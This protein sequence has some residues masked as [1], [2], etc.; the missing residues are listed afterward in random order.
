M[1]KNETTA[2]KTNGNDLT[3][4]VFILD[5][6]GSMFSLAEDTVGGF[7]AML[8]KQKGEDG[9]CLVTTVFF[10]SEDRRVHDRI[11]LAEVPL[12]TGEDYRPGGCTALYDAMGHTVEHIRSIHRYARPEDVPARTLVIVTTDG[13][14]NA[15]RSY[16]SRKVR[17][18]VR[19]MQEEWGWEFL[20]LGANM[21]AIAAAENVGIRRE[22]ATTYAC[23]K[24]GTRLNFKA[25]AKVIGDVRAA[26][27][28]SDDWDE[29]ITA[30]REEAKR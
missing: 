5:E 30:Y 15:S 11:P 27:A 14:E 8:E 1:K 4:L 18:L 2:K 25:C 26:R 22:R 13:M 28:V 12:L 24:A 16:T 23:D 7:N 29:E 3:E 6:S 9:R 20:F 19:E 17:S 21:D 10:N